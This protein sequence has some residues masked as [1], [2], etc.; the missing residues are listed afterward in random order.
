MKKVNISLGIIFIWALPFHGMALNLEQL[1]SIVSSQLCQGEKCKI[2]CDNRLL[3]RIGHDLPADADSC[4]A[5]EQYQLLEAGLYRTTYGEVK[6]LK[7]KFALL[8]KQKKVNLPDIHAQQVTNKISPY[9]IDLQVNPNKP[10]APSSFL[11]VKL[12][13]PTQQPL[14]NASNFITKPNIPSISKKSPKNKIISSL[15][16]GC[17]HYATFGHRGGPVGAENSIPAVL[18]GLKDRHNGVEIDTQRLIDGVWVVH[19]DPLIGR[20]SYG[21]TGFVN[22]LSSEQW[23]QVFLLNRKGKETNIKAPLLKDLLKAFSQHAVKGQVINIEIKM[24][25]AKQYSCDQLTALNQQVRSILKPSQFFFT[26]T[27][28][29]AL[30]CIRNINHGV[31][32]GLIIEPNEQSLKRVIDTQYGAEYRS[33]KQH[34]PL[35]WKT[36]L[37]NNHQSN[38]EW[39]LRNNYMDLKSMIGPNFGLHIDYRDID[40]MTGKIEAAGGRW[41]IYELNDDQGM[42]NILKTRIIKHQLIPQAVIIDS[43]KKTFCQAW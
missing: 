24:V 42:L 9:I 34:V 4:H 3:Q 7:R 10:I 11:P 5:K 1:E 15:H 14:K 8:S 40:R 19:H 30:Q 35:W 37:K 21:I 33:F 18:S 6:S 12:K 17:Q 16:L 31:Y 32:L 20:S 22:L 36:A 25:K 13:P 2:D 23:K 41:M 43:P 38:R 27:Y 29:D 28:L 26:S 39:L